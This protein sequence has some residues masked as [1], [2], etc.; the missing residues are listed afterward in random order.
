MLDQAIA[1]QQAL[2]RDDA[3]WDG[4]L[5]WLEEHPRHRLLFDEVALLDRMIDERAAALGRL[6]TPAPAPAPAPSR[7]NRRRWLGGAVAAALVAAV[8]VPMLRQ[9]A[10]D[11]VYAT[12]AGQTRR[13]AL[14]RGEVVDLAPSSRLVLLGG[15]ARRLELAAGEALFS[16]V[17]DPSR[18]LNVRAGRFDV[19]DIGTTFGIHLAGARVAVTVADGDVSV[20]PAGGGRGGRHVGA[21]ERFVGGRGAADRVTAVAREDV[22]SWRHGRLVYDEAPLTLVAADLARYSGR[23]VTVDPALA[24][25]RFSGVLQV[26][27]GSRL[28]G[29]VSDLMGIGYRVERGRVR[30]AADPAG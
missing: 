11:I 17:H 14:G 23:T 1:W 6:A 18:L 5:A 2:A 28:F 8:A 26:G 25:R 3:D 12:A 30:F 7:T 19:T 24:D 9:P 13:I 4:Y 15:D 29:D 16:V 22:G 10:A 20:G 27:D 21:G